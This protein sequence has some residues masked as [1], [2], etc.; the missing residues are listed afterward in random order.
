LSGRCGAEKVTLYTVGYEGFEVE[1]FVKFLK[2]N[3][4]EVIA[5]LRKNPVSRKR[6][7]SKNKLAEQ[8]AKKKIDYVHYVNLGTPSQW[9]KMESQGKI[10]REKMFQLYVEKILPAAS[11]E[12]ISLRELMRKKTTAVLCYE[13]DAS[14]CHRSYVANEVRRLEKRKLKVVDL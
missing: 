7:F 1:D 9:R 11:K 4:I 13:A 8:L 10:S 6:G 14:D 2:K 3:H 5:D 12:L